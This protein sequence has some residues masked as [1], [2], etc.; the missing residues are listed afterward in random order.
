MYIVII[1]GL[2]IIG[3]LI[4]YIISNHNKFKFAIIEIDEAENNIEV[5]LQKKIDLINRTIPIIKKELKLDSF[6]DDMNF[7]N[8]SNLTHFEIYN[9]LCEMNSKLMVTLDENEKLFKSVQLTNI[10]EE[11]KDV[12]EDIDGSIKFYNDSVTVFNKLIVS[13]PSKIIAWMFRYK[14]KE[15]YNNETREM[16]DIINDK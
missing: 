16:F 2:L 6:L 4:S 8:S 7:L 1:G 15:F 9:H 10:L 11:I 14:R 5:L 3:F 12:D 13:F